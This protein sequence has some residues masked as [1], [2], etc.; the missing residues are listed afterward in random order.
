MADVRICYA[1]DLTSD[2][3]GKQ[4]RFEAGPDHSRTIFID[5]LTHV[6][7]RRERTNG[8]E[9]PA[10]FEVVTIVHLERT[11]W[12]EAGLFGAGTGRDVGLSIPHTSTVEVL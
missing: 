2:A 12:R 1:G 10:K 11:T 8:H 5:V 4:I 3:I 7:H 6:E 9:Y